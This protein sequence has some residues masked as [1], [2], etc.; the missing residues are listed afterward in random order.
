MTLLHYKASM[1]SDQKEAL[2]WLSY[3]TLVL[4][5]C[6][7]HKSYISKI[8]AA[9]LRTSETAFSWLLCFH[10]AIFSIHSISMTTFHSTIFFLK[11]VSFKEFCGK[12][13]DNKCFKNGSLLKSSM[14]RVVPYTVNP[15]TNVSGLRCWDKKKVVGTHH[16][17]CH[18]KKCRYIHT[19]C[20]SLQT[21]ATRYN[22]I[23]IA[24]HI[25]QQNA[26]LISR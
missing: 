5:E 11:Q 16:W 15:S 20:H 22:L 25:K 14:Q 24:I 3:Y 21:H 17:W 12:F 13:M 26:N 9:A 19:P 2:W 23:L 10:G 8:V 6:T 4:Q 18:Y 7:C 1:V